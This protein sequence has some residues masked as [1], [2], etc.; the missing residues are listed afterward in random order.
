[1]NIKTERLLITDLS[2]DMA[3]DIQ[4]N[5]VDEDNK[6]FVPDEVFETVEQ[7]KEVVQWLLDSYHSPTG[8]FLYP[9][10]TNNQENIGYVQVCTIDEGWEIGYH[11]AK[12]YTGKGY[13]TEAVKAFLPVILPQ[14]HIHK[15][16]G[17]VLEENI[18]SHKVLE[19]CG[20]RLDYKG[21]ALYQGENRSLRKYIFE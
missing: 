8:P 16:Y 19:H 4:R 18:A 9:I 11:I 5:S 3:A 17:I 20:F 10:L 21:I 7:T 1:M 14:L 2:L 13:A 15:I 6:K 12:E